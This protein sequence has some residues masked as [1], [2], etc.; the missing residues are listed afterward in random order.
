MR[1]VLAP[2]GRSLED[3]AEGQDSGYEPLSGLISQPASVLVSLK[4]PSTDSLRHQSN[5]DAAICSLLASSIFLSS[6]MAS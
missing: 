3:M 1:L 2:L 4:L 5:L 6:S